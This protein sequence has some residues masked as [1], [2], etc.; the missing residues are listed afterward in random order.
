MAVIIVAIAVVAAVL[1][2][3]RWAAVKPDTCCCDLSPAKQDTEAPIACS[4][5]GD[6]F[7]ERAVWIRQLARSS[8]RRADRKPLSLALTYDPAALDDVRELVRREQ[9]CCAFLDFSLSQDSNGVHLTVTAPQNAREAAEILFDH[10][11]PELARETIIQ[12]KEPA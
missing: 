3:R 10:F 8:L 2:R 9:T 5:S 6:D 12:Q 4:L 1:L 11:A 7:R